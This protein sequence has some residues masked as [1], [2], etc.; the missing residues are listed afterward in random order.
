MLIFVINFSKIIYKKQ[1]VCSI[2]YKV[3]L[4]YIIL[5]ILYIKSADY[6]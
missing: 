5:L 3:W 6:I 1:S 4:I 2:I